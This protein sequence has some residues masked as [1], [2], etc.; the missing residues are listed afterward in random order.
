MAAAISGF[1]PRQA[2]Q[3]M[4]ESVNQCLQN[5]DILIAEAG[6]GVG[7]TFAYLVPALMSGQ[8]VIVSTGTRHLQD[9]LYHRD[10][11]RMQKALGIGLRTALLKGR[12][13]YLC[14]HR[15]LQAE[16][17][18]RDTVQLAKLQSIKSWSK[19]TK[20]GDIAEM[21][22]VA[23]GDSVW[24]HATSTPDNC[25][26]AECPDYQKCH[27]VKAR[28]HAQE[29]DL[30]VVNHHLFFADMALKD[31]G[32]GEVLP[33]A[34][35]FIFDEAH[36]LPDTATRFFGESVSARQLDLL[37]QDCVS[38]QIN[39]A[40][41]MPVVRD[42]AEELK[43]ETRELRMAL[44]SSMRRDSW[45]MIAQKPDVKESFAAVERALQQLSEEL[46]E[47]SDRSPDL[48][49][50]A[51]RC[52]MM[53]KRM[54]L[55][56]EEEPESI[57]WFDTHQY[58]FAIHSTP[59]E[60]GEIFAQHMHKF[61]AA[62]V[63]TSATLSVA[64]SFEHFQQR[65]GITEAETAAFDSPFDYQR[66]ALL[67]LPEKMPEPSSYDFVQ[68]LVES[69]LPVL[70]A[71]EGR[72]FI[73]FTSHRALQQAAGLLEKKIDHPLFVQGDMPR[74]Q[75]LDEFRS[76][77]N[78]VLLGTSS[79]WEGVDIRGEALSCVI[80]DKLP[81]AAPN[82]PVLKARLDMIRQR[83]GVPFA[84]YQL[85]QAVITLKQGIGRL[86]RDVSD[87]GVL[88]IAD[89]RLR[90]KGYGKMFLASLPDMPITSEID[91]VER[92]FADD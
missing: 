38:A 51:A 61:H 14:V 36:Q 20:S 18:V 73:L 35:A 33:T 58:G 49:K 52:A 37:V 92:F 22:E 55:F 2:Q 42:H 68:R 90:T 30:V 23:E 15:L 63:F 54:Q 53:V 60:I 28:R 9:Q 7:K 41:D 5:A 1:A 24:G 26:A 6:T 17:T 84:E 72:A 66:N 67:Y 3:N 44:G 46:M 40:P 43:Q 77:G 87:R 10:L 85:P 75:L 8:R 56:Q 65:M 79:F 59:L 64:G 70:A 27:L 80:I 76:S 45:S 78:G 88:M 48:E 50:C 47:L 31:E 71:S 4:A 83:G 91:E 62:W 11:P 29:A 39:D 57:L 12:S 74:S 81:F 21:T 32:F 86:I 25:L 34:D 89:P 82:D 69:S 16:H 13:N 19:L